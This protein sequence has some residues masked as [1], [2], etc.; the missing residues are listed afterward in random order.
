[1]IVLTVVRRAFCEICGGHFDLEPEEQLPPTCRMCGSSCWLWGRLKRGSAP[2]LQRGAGGQRKK[3]LK[4][5][6]ALDPG[7][8]HRNRQIH[9]KAQWRQFKDR[10]TYEA[11]KALEDRAPKGDD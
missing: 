10:E 7:V 1:M 9:G 3:P 11:A 6:P 5:K 2:W 8:K 4:E